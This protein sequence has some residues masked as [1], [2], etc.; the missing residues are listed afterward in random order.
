MALER[1]GAMT[2]AL[3]VGAAALG[4]FLA[5]PLGCA[6]GA[7][8]GGLIGDIFGKSAVALVATCA[9]KG[10]EAIAEKILG[11]QLD[12]LA[13]KFR[14]RKQPQIERAYREAFHESLTLVHLHVGNQFEKWFENWAACLKSSDHLDLDEIHP[15]QIVPSNLEAM[16]S[17]TMQRLD[18]QGA[19]I[20][21]TSLTLNI[22]YRELPSAIFLSVCSSTRPA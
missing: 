21:E 7:F 14:E 19:A 4:S 10:G 9:E 15:F 6:T 11:S 17:H 16:L 8:L 18:A 5:G 3:R 2:P 22:K 12:S 13:E 1:S 20:R